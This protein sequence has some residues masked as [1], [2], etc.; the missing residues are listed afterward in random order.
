MDQPVR[1]REAA[2]LAGAV[3]RFCRSLVRRAAAGD[4]HALRELL[5]LRN[6]LPEVM[7]IAVRVATTVGPYTPEDLT[8][9]LAMTRQGVRQLAARTISPDGWTYYTEG[10]NTDET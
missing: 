6:E 8:T 3:R 1:E 4:V 10:I 7:R 9:D 2:E 5:E